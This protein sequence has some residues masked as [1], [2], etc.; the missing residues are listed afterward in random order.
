MYISRIARGVVVSYV[1]TTDKNRREKN[2]Q[3]TTIITKRNE[4]FYVLLTIFTISRL[5]EKKT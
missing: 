3:H 4:L 2:L 5:K 1:L